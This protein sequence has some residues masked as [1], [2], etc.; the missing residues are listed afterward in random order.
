M[1]KSNES[2]G[3]HVVDKQSLNILPRPESIIFVLSTYGFK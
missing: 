2:H 1:Q 3:T